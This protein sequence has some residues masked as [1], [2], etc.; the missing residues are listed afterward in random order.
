MLYWHFYLTTAAAT[1]N[2]FILL[3]IE[4][5]DAFKSFTHR[6]L[7]LL[8]FTFAQYTSNFLQCVSHQSELDQFYP[9]EGE[10]DL[11]TVAAL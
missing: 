9:Q 11:E 10:K 2:C 6:S 1:L 3:S 7:I 4:I 8:G 5:N